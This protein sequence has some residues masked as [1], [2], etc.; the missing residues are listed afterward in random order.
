MHYNCLI[1]DDEEDLAR[2]TCEY[3]QLFDISCEQV[4][5]IASTESFFGASGGSAAP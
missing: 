2:M 1:V 4:P 5:D 3:F